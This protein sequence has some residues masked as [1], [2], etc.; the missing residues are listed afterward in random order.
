[1]SQLLRC[2]KCKKPGLEDADLMWV[3]TDELHE[4]L[5]CFDCAP[6]DALR[7]QWPVDEV[8]DDEQNQRSN[9]SNAH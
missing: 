7:Q 9:D 5:L 6:E 1:M 3:A 4:Q 2:V 8:E